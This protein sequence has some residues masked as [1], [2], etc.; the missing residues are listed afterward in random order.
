MRKVVEMTKVAETL[1]VLAG[2]GCRKV[3]QQWENVESRYLCF[4][5]NF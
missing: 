1:G 3:Q 2:R 4:D 5:G